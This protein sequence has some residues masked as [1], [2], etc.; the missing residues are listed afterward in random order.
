[1]QISSL[2]QLVG[3]DIG[4]YRVE[5][6]LGRGQVNAVYLAYHS[7]HN[8][9]VAL[10]IFI[11]PE[12]FS[13][14]ARQCFLLRFRKEAARLALLQQDHILP[15]HDYGEYAGFPY[16]VT[17]YMTYGSLTNILKRQGRLRHADVLDVLQQTGAG[18]AYAHRKGIFHGA[19]KPS[20][21]VLNNQGQMLVA[22]F[23][24]TQILQMH[25]IEQDER[26]YGHLCNIAGTFLT[27]A[28]YIA[29]EIVQGQPAD[30][31]TDI[32]SLGAIL[33][34]LLSGETPFTGNDPL[35]IAI[36]HVH[37]PIPSL[38][39]HGPDIPPDLVAI[40]NQALERDPARRFQRV[41]ELVE[42]FTQVCA[43][44][45][46]NDTSDTIGF[47]RNVKLQE[48]PP[49]GYA[50]G[51]WQLLPPIITEKVAAIS[52]TSQKINYQDLI[53][54]T[55]PTKTSLS[56]LER[57]A[58]PA[59]LPTPYPTRTRQDPQES[60][61]DLWTSPLQEP[62][63]RYHPDSAPQE[64]HQAKRRPTSNLRSRPSTGRKTRTNER[65]SRRKVVA[66]LVAGGVILTG[67]TVALN[68]IGN[69]TNQQAQNNAAHLAK[70][71]ALN[72]VN[73]ANS[74]ASVLVHLTNGNFAA[75][76]R[77]CTHKG[78]YV[79]YDPAKKL[80]VCPAHGATFDPANNGAVVQGVANEPPLNP[81]PKVAV[82]I[83]ADGTIAAG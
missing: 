20:N 19:L 54:S 37:Q 7:T 65:V 27:R 45:P 13:F 74:K 32:Y 67:A 25:G 31:R 60:L 35:A 9:R 28:E 12:K 43:A 75:Y 24:L 15:I 42:A 59:L 14:E 50:H 48:T 53:R 76:D 71:A 55:S 11:L 66:S 10:M 77:A 18:L 33:F 70:N 46:E 22:G 64:A 80:L 1:M 41:D 68:L 81:L 73:P 62:V 16:L 26:P 56:S 51:N 47:V 78:V 8:S 21:I 6:L 40:V 52:P 57:S 3:Q 63:S 17:P 23:G 72:F 36:Q 38:H 83:N 4:S 29:P 34:E 69:A 30:A 44:S 79:A 39:T 61:F 2:D 58:T 49:N 5:Q 82:H